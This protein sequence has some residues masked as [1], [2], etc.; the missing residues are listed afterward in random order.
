LP[1]GQGQRGIEK[2][3]GILENK[4]LTESQRG[5]KKIVASPQATIRIKAR[6]FF[7][8]TFGFFYATIA[9]TKRK[10]LEIKKRGD[11]GR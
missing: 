2:R 9:T 5:T 4:Y 8:F 7:A 3:S 1:F 10:K 6:I 11:F